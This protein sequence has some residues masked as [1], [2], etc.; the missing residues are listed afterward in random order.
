MLQLAIGP[1]RPAIGASALAQRGPITKGV[2]RARKKFPVRGS[3]AL[4]FVTARCG[5]ELVRQ[6]NGRV[7]NLFRDAT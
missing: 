7:L 4:I 3:R 5:D 1:T 2:E 6:N